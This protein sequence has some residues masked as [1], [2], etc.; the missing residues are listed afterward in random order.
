M[1]EKITTGVHTMHKIYIGRQ[2]ILD[3]DN[4][5][6]AYELFFRHGKANFTVYEDSVQ[7][8]AR[9]LV[10]FLMNFGINNLIGDKLGFVNIDDRFLMTD[11]IEAL[12]QDRIVFEILEHSTIS[13]ELVERVRDLS[14]KGYRFA[15]DEVI[16]EREYLTRFK[17]LV[18]KVEFIKVDFSLNSPRRLVRMAHTYRQFYTT[19]IIEKMEN[20]RDVEL[21]RKLG[22]SLFQGYY[23]AHTEVIEGHAYEP[24]KL[25]VLKTIQLLNSETSTSQEIESELK[26]CPELSV[27]LLKYINSG[28]FYLRSNIASLHHAITLMGRIKLQ[29]WLLLL[30]Y[31]DPQNGGLRGPVFESA[32]FRAKLMEEIA[33]HLYGSASAEKDQSFLV[34]ILSLVDVIF[35][36]DKTEIIS[37]LKL[38][39]VVSEAVLHYEGRIGTMLQLVEA[40]EKQTTDTVEGYAAGLGLDLDALENMRINT[41]EFL[42][43]FIRTLER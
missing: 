10:N 5:I 25:T 11:A 26:F 34:G 8:S 36:M 32:I 15:L 33:A 12:P 2:P 23:F 38:S 19:L 16:F 24:S 1:T 40:M 42:Q 4:Q 31:S 22:F 37:S 30:C 20:R 6:V 7:A 3:A 27:N 29:N 13:D 9:T 35:Q 41:Y 18:D 43:N 28:A 17:N 14:F 21:C 39:E